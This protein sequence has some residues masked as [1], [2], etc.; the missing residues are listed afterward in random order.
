VQPY[1]PAGWLRRFE[2]QAGPDEAER[3]GHALAYKAPSSD[4][5]TNA[6]Q[7]AGRPPITLRMLHPKGRRSAMTAREG[8]AIA[9]F[10]LV[11][12]CF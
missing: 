1:V 3:D 10:S 4:T 7:Q 12:A 6:R 9:T 11:H 2:G 8:N 5:S